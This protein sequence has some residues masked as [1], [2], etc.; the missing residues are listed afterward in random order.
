[1]IKRILCKFNKKGHKISLHTRR[2]L[3]CG[4]YVPSKEK[5]ITGNF[6]I[7]PNKK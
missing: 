7:E 5:Q 1:M 2:C 4:L 3:K 6:Q